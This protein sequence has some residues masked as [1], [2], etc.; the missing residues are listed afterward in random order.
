MKKYLYLFL[1]LVVACAF[2]ACSDDDDEAP[3]TSSALSI[4]CNGN[5]VKN[6]EVISYTAKENEFEEI[7]A[8]HDSE[9]R[10]TSKTSCNM[11]V[12]ITIPKHE[13]DRFDWCGI[14]EMCMPCTEPGVYTREA[15]NTT[16][17]K[18]NLHAYFQK[19]VYTSCMVQVDVKVNGKQER[20][21][22][23]QYNYPEIK[24]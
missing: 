12:S 24:K 14:T 9:P 6:K 20:T 2:V 7:V 4:V 15:K 16:S 11:E 5:E 10:F 23:L 3:A 19:G 17:S 8:G 18:M 22:F 21:F 1:S 13:L